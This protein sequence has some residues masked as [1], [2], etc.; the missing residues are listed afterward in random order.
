MQSEKRISFTR[1]EMVRF[2]AKAIRKGVWF[3]ALTTIE[4]ACVDLAIKVVE[5]VRS[6]L[7]F[8]ALS[9]VLKKLE[10]ALESQVRRLM[11]EVGGRIASKMSQIAQNWGNKSA[12][13]WAKE[14]GFIQYLTVD[15]LN[16]QH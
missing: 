4:R 10:D 8:K 16:A 12:A 5:R 11:R 1:N 15:Y 6:R 9:S 2:R 3:R 14:L 13:R 7:L